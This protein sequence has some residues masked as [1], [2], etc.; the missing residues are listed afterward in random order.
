M[1]QVLTLTLIAI[2]FASC[3]TTKIGWGTGNGMN[4]NCYKAK[5]RMPNL[6]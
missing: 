3:T 1:R 5:H 6:N 4:A 2:I